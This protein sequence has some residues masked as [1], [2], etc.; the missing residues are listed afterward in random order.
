[1]STFLSYNM[2]CLCMGLLQ[3]VYILIFFIVV[4][5][6]MRSLSVRSDYF[7]IIKK[8]TVLVLSFVT[9]IHEIQLLCMFSCL[10]RMFSYV[11]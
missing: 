7:M 4:S 10:R 1:M 9:S 2:I 8:K 3:H 5:I 6:Q 11:D